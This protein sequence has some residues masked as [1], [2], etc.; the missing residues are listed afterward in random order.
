MK[1]VL[2]IILLVLG[3][4]IF[5]STIVA[6]IHAILSTYLFDRRLSRIMED[7]RK[8]HDEFIEESEDEEQ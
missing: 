2:E 7:I 6:I 3:I 8:E 1:E 5:I 4:I